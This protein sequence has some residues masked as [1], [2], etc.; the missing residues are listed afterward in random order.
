MNV[1][2]LYEKRWKIELAFRDIKHALGALHFHSK[3]DLFNLQE[4]VAHLIR[5]NLVSRII[6]QVRLA[7]PENLKYNY[8][9]NF[10]N[11]AQIVQDHCRYVHFDY[12][13]IF[14]QISKH[15]HPVRQDR[16]FLRNCRYIHP[17]SFNY[18]VA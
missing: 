6:R 14:D 2:K 5:Y 8:E 1:K 18:R 13:K 16:L 17:V 9:I 10:K 7:K 4:F 12:G 3:K 15:V 11:A